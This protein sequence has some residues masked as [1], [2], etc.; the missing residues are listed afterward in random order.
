MSVLMIL[1]HVSDPR[2]QTNVFLFSCR[3][4][5]LHLGVGLILS[6]FCCKSEAEVGHLVSARGCP[7]LWHHLATRS[8]FP[9][10]IA[11]EPFLRRPLAV[12]VR[13]HCWVLFCYSLAVPVTLKVPS[14]LDRP[15][16]GSWRESPDSVLPTLFGFLLS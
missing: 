7:G 10:Q 12:F 15:E 2:L 1:G 4:C 14:R 5:I 16:L 6:Y 9:S 3:T 13:G 8:S 11:F